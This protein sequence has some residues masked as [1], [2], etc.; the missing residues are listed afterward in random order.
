MKSIRQICV[1]LLVLQ[2]IQANSLPRPSGQPTP[3][4]AT[5]TH[6]S[7]QPTIN[8]GLLGSQPLR[9]GDAPSLIQSIPPGLLKKKSSRNKGG[10]V[11]EEGEVPCRGL[12]PFLEFLGRAGVTIYQNVKDAPKGDTV[13]QTEWSQYMTCCQGQSLVQY[14]NADKKTIL[15]HVD[16]VNQE[17]KDFIET[18]EA[19]KLRS[20]EL[21]YFLENTVGFKGI[22][23]YKTAR[24]LFKEIG[25]SYFKNLKSSTGVMRFAKENEKCW[26]Q[27]IN[28]RQTSLCA[29][30]SSRSSEFF[31]N[32]HVIVAPSVCAKIVMECKESFTNMDN[33]LQDVADLQNLL[34]ITKKTH[35]ILDFDQIPAKY[36]L[37]V[38]SSFKN[39][40][41]DTNFGRISNSVDLDVALKAKADSPLSTY[42]CG[43]TLNLVSSPLIET[44]SIASLPINITIPTDSRIEKLLAQRKHRSKVARLKKKAIHFIIDKIDVP[45]RLASLP[46][47]LKFKVARNIQMT[48]DQN[49]KSIKSLEK[50]CKNVHGKIVCRS[51]TKHKSGNVVIKNI[52]DSKKIYK[53]N[54]ISRTRHVGEDFKMV[55]CINKISFKA[56]RASI[57]TKNAKL[58][59]KSSNMSKNRPMNQR[60]V[61]KYGNKKGRSRLLINYMPL[62]KHRLITSP[63]R[64]LSLSKENNFII[65]LDSQIKRSKAMTSSSELTSELSSSVSSIVHVKSSVLSISGEDK[66]NSIF[67]TDTVIMKKSD[68]MF[69]SFDG[70]KG[71][72]LDQLNFHIEP[73]NFASSFP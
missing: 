43:M 54:S 21:D 12:N 47:T 44:L 32:G 1:I 42:I 31:I 37:D 58:H 52:R 13:C 63:T 28:I 9:V 24:I 5:A 2:A 6:P 18:I 36:R 66:V 70:A 46:A 60:T 34:K 62:S 35:Q 38:A 61:T 7:A 22:Q 56:N 10:L 4:T 68:N 50:S 26:K 16:R 67:A 69:S 65:S 17:Y 30:C 71:T 53:R 39:Q 48:N 8:G 49:T 59:P 11:I 3:E 29:T 19:I 27:M 55:K 15:K 14:A 25:D 41:L 64:G 51:S 23:K 73:M 33:Y 20:L 45:G 72:T 57:K 40:F